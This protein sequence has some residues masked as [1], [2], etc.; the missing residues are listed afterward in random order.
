MELTT[1]VMH[2]HKFHSLRAS[3]YL[4]LLSELPA[5]ITEEITEEKNLTT[6]FHF[7]QA[8]LTSNVDSETDVNFVSFFFFFNL[9]F[10]EL[11]YKVRLVISIQNVR[12]YL[13]QADLSY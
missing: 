8:E 12:K 3:K 9:T 5:V 13:T 11:I 6:L 10:I 7:A 2:A 4:G 1:R